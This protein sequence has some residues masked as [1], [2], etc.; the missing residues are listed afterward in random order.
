MNAQ[1]YRDVEAAL[2]H[3]L[4]TEVR[5]HT[6][7][8]EG[9]SRALRVLEVGEGDGEPVVFIHGA[10]AS[11]ACWA[12]LLPALSGYRCL[13]VDRPG[14]GLSDRIPS[15]FRDIEALNHFADTFLASILDRLD[16]DAAHLVGNSFG[17]FF[18]VRSAAAT[19]ER[20]RRLGL[21]GYTVGAPLEKMPLVMRAGVVP[22]VGPLMASIP[23]P[24]RAVVSMM[25]Q[26]GLGEA[27][28]AGRISDEAIDWFHSL[29]RDTRTMRNEIRQNPPIMGPIKGLDPEFLLTDT[30]LGDVTAPALLVWG[31]EDF[32]GGA[33]AART[34]TDALGEATLH[35]LPGAGHAPWLDDPET[36]A[37][38]LG[39]HLRTA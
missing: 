33:A 30:L 2:W 25:K 14:C 21:F 12:P 8:F 3:S 23:P 17:G 31:T 10:S 34:M 32:Y 27:M 11:G 15:R 39:A 6:L 24:R 7:S 29:L 20:V 26:I 38:L 9:G 36:C 16:I 35:M 19:P 4:D 22:G 1:R 28:A 18:A 5:E 37:D 13:L